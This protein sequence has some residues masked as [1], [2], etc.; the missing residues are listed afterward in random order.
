M[1]I[2]EKIKRIKEIPKSIAENEEDRK[3]LINLTSV[4]YDKIGFSSSKNN[5][6]ESK[7][8]CYTDKGINIDELTEERD[9]LIREIQSEIDSR[10]TGTDVN[11]IDTRRIL[12]LYFL[13]NHNLKQ[14]SSKFIYRSYS[15]VKSLFQEGCKKLKISLN[16]PH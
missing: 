5:S 3:R 4:N 10:I 13:D 2:S 6:A 7:D 12:K 14:I 1:T 8:I 16:N 15:I 9:Q 11:S